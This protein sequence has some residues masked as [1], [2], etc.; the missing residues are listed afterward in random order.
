MQQQKAE[1]DALPKPG[2]SRWRSARTDKGSVLSYAKDVQE[3]HKKKFGDGDP[4]LR[5]ASQPKRSGL[6]LDSTELAD[7]DNSF[8]LNNK[9][10]CAIF[11]FIFMF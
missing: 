9:I 10:K 3:K 8:P 6:R 4:V 7:S 2:G 11:F 5:A 1:D